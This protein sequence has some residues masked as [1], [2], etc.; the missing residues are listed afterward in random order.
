MHAYPDLIRWPVDE[1]RQRARLRF[2]LVEDIPTLLDDFA[3]AVAYEIQAAK[4]E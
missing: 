4:R 3:C 2:R 1:L